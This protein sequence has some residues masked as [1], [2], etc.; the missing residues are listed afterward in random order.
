MTRLRRWFLA[1]A[2]VILALLYG[3]P[4]AIICAYSLF[5]R[6]AY[7]GVEGAI[8]VAN[9]L[10]LAD[11]LYL[12]I[13]LR[14]FL[15]ASAATALCLVFAF[16]LAWF[17]AHAGPRKHFYL[18]LVVLPFWTSILIC[19][20]SWM[21]LLR[22]TGLVNTV[23]LELGW[24]T[25]PLPLLYNYGAVLLGLVYNYLPFMVLPIYAA[26]ERLDPHL[27]EAA[28]D[29]GATPAATF[30]RVVLPLAAPG[31]RAG[32]VLVFIPSLGD[33][34]TPDLLGGGR[35]ILIGNLIQNQFT[36]ARDYPFG[37]AVSLALMSVVMLLLWRLLKR[38]EEALL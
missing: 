15:M 36:A 29:L 3:V 37:A 25:G 16:P 26:L 5:R 23:L 32:A 10:R 11:P 34:L 17:I 13:L 7:G 21:F 2:A 4:L 27:V 1:P 20:Y 6:G 35:T 30:R 9:F 33:Y 22:D 12:S 8:S 14:S 19:M 18:A 28:S 38:Q 31:V 24:T